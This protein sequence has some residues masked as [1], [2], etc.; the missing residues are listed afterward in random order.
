M[1]ELRLFAFWLANGTLGLPVLEGVPYLEL[2]GREPSAIEQT[3][4]IFANVLEV[5]E[6]GQVVNARAAQQRA[7]QYLRSYCDPSYEVVPPL[8][9]WEVEL[10]APAV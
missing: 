5:D 1:Y 2:M 9:D 4:A 7:A 6:R 8:E 3:M 10:H